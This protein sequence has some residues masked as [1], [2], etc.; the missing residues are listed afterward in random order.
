MDWPP[1]HETQIRQEDHDLLR[2]PPSF[3]LIKCL[4][5]SVSG[6]FIL[7][8]IGVM[9]WQ[10]SARSINHIIPS[11]DSGRLSRLCTAFSNFGRQR[12]NAALPQQ[13]HPVHPSPSW[14][15]V[16]QPPRCDWTRT[17][18]A[19]HRGNRMMAILTHE[20]KWQPLNLTPVRARRRGGGGP[21]D[22]P[23]ISLRREDPHAFFLFFFF[24]FFFPPR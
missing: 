6:S 10:A 23:H 9:S 19:C 1:T 18:P 3:Y 20:R 4:S 8:H 22:S 17:S 15:R 21:L 13:Q 2:I 11:L 12:Q 5:K 7:R 14:I 16:L 24:L